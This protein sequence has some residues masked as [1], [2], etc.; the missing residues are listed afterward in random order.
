MIFNLLGCTNLCTLGSNKRDNVVA[1][2]LSDNPYQFKDSK[3][4]YGEDNIAKLL[5]KCIY[6][7][8]YPR[9]RILYEILRCEDQPNHQQL[10]RQGAVYQE[11]PKTPGRDDTQRLLG[12]YGKVP[13]LEETIIS[14][15]A[16]C[17]IGLIIS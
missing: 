14:V 1:I 2:F 11:K 9:P 7:A 13:Q 10:E 16:L 3:K 17:K 15:F 6:F 12:G 5:T 4:N 8:D